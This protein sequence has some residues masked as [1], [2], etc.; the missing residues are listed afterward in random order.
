MSMLRVS[1]LQARSSF[2]KKL[3][4]RSSYDR[5]DENHCGREVSPASADDGLIESVTRRIAFA[6][7]RAIGTGAEVA[8]AHILTVLEG[9]I[10]L[11]WSV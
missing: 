6:V 5:K 1:S 9:W 2:A 10:T 11:C 4:S 8:M 3:R 7:R